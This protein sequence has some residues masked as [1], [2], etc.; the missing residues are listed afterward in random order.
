MAK[1]RELSPQEIDFIDSMLDE[2]AEYSVEE[3]DDGITIKN[4]SEGKKNKKIKKKMDPIKKL[5]IWFFVIGSIAILIGCG[6]AL[7]IFYLQEYLGGAKTIDYLTKEKNNKNSEV[8]NAFN[9][10]GMN[11]VPNFLSIYENKT[12]IFIAIGV[13][14]LLLVIIFVIIDSKTTNK[15]NK[16]EKNNNNK[17]TNEP[18]NDETNNTIE[19]NNETNNPIED[20]EQKEQETKNDEYV[21]ENDEYVNEKLDEILGEFSIPQNLS[22]NNIQEDTTDIKTEKEN[23]TRQKML[24]DKN[25]KKTY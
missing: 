6:I 7:S 4:H 11:W 8:I 16:K 23:L 14:L 15:Y 24:A 13:L 9:E 3:N 17:N 20:H 25:K 2:K 19:N 21:N 18:I 5:R 1:K 12:I 10:V 22:N